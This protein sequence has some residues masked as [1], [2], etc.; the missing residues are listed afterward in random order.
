MQVRM[1]AVLLLLAL[2]VL[3]TNVTGQTA[4][5]PGVIS[6]DGKLLQIEIAGGEVGISYPDDINVA[7]EVSSFGRKTEQLAHLI[8][9]YLAIAERQEDRELSDQ[10]SLFRSTSYA[11]KLVEKIE[12]LIERIAF[13]G[14]Q[15]ELNTKIR[16]AADAFNVQALKQLL[17]Q[18]LA[19]EDEF[20]AEAAY[21]LAGFQELDGEFQDAWGNYQKASNLQPENQLYMDAHGKNEF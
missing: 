4:G 18:K 11:K 20:V 6:I 13:L 3:A 2:A 14:D 10:E 7:G 5:D 8:E 16:L 17:Q 19:M 1:I 21:Q 9:K 12:M 15:D